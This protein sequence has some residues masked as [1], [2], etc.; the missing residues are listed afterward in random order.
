MKKIPL[1]MVVALFGTITADAQVACSPKVESSTC[2]TVASQWNAA[3]DHMI[4][5]GATISVELLGPNEYAQRVV[6]T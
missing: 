3:L 2:Q 5:R 6:D 4:L 1:A